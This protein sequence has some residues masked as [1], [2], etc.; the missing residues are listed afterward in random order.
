[1][2][3]LETL[4]E[5]REAYLCMSHE[6]YDDTRALGCHFQ[7]NAARGIRLKVLVVT[8]AMDCQVQAKESKKRSA[9]STG[10]D[11]SQ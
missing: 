7:M 1:M 11:E 3:N 2:G 10:C 9:R 6:V 5:T 4:D 8:K